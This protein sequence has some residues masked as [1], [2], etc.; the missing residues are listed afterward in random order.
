[1]ADS[2]ILDRAYHYLVSQVVKTGQAHYS[3]LATGL[4]CT[5]EEGRQLVYD[6]AEAVPSGIRLN[7][8]TAWITP[9]TPFSLLPTPFRIP[10]DRQQKWFGI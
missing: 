10:V 8:G 4:G 6:L 9:L 1:M 3:A 5:T 7:P 2:Q